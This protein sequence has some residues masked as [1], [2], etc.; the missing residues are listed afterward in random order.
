MCL[1]IGEIICECKTKAK[2]V[3][4]F[5]S[6]HNNINN[7]TKIKASSLFNNVIVLPLY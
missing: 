6:S 7:K 3:V 5:L 4:T 2:N 1:N